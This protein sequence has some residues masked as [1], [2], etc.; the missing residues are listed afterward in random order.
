MVNGRARALAGLLLLWP[1]QVLSQQGCP[2]AADL[3]RGIEATFATGD[4]IVYRAGGEPGTVLGE[5]AG[6]EGTSYRGIVA[7]GGFS[8]SGAG[9]TPD[10]QPYAV[11]FDYGRPGGELPRIAPG[12]RERI[13]FTTVTS[14]REI[15]MVQQ[16]VAGEVE[17]VTLSGCTYEGI[18]VLV[19][20]EGGFAQQFLYLP[21]LG[22]RMVEWQEWEG[23][24]RVVMTLT[25]FRVL[26]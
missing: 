14:D 12:M 22:I 3:S 6:P 17:P 7:P 10:G 23:R 8:V 21:D 16:W 24:P 18:R 26:P 25:G 5:G 11:R 20:D 13:A 2:T 19:A 4:R 15:P 1:F 9:V